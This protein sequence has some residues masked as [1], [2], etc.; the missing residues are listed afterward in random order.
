MDSEL[1]REPA[2]IPCMWQGP[3]QTGSGQASAW[4]KKGSRWVEKLEESLQ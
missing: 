4:E 1:D 3:G 2:S